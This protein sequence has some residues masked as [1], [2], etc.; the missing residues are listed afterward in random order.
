MTT[1]P[2]RCY[3]QRRGEQ[4]PP[5][6]LQRYLIVG[7]SSSRPCVSLYLLAFSFRNIS[8]L[9]SFPFHRRHQR[10][11]LRKIVHCKIN[12]IHQ[13][14]RAVAKSCPLLSIRIS[15]YTD[16]LSSI[17]GGGGKLPWESA[18]KWNKKSPST[19]KINKINSRR[20]RFKS[21]S[22]AFITVPPWRWTQNLTPKC[23]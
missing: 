7:L 14:S 5:Q 9:Y 20:N 10:I 23:R 8:H 11:F 22:P 17:V 15:L 4:T 18:Q 3:R 2:Q 1:Q 16:G 13:Y 12:T 6:N 21:Y 19:Q